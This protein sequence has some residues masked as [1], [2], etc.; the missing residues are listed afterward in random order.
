MALKPNEINH[1][2][3]REYEWF[4]ASTAGVTACSSPKS[5]GNSHILSQRSDPDFKSKTD[6][7]RILTL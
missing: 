2:H 6:I 4:L 5:L 7:R 3:L 1:K